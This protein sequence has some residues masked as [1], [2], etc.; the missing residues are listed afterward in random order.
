MVSTPINMSSPHYAGFWIRFLASLF[1][2]LIIGIPAALIFGLIAATKMNVLYWVVELASVV[3][4]VYLNG[5]KGGTPGKFI[6]GIRIVNVQGQFIGIPISIL[7]H[8]GYIVS[9]ITLGIGYLMIA[10]TAKKQGLHDM[11]AKTY[12]VYVR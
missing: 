5:I 4:I 2:I 1:D 6:V 7:R 10:F 11:I 12:V 8:I 3:L 9:D